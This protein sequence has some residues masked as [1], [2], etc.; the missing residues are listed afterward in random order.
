MKNSNIREKYH[1][2]TPSISLA[3]IH[4]CMSHSGK[5]G[6]KIQ[7]DKIP[8]KYCLKILQLVKNT[9]KVFLT[10]FYKTVNI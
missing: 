6:N 7:I 2:F 10:I 8:K 1:L 4:Q 9:D 3:S 5:K